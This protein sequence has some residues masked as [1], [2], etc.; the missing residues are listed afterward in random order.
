MQGFVEQTIGRVYC[1]PTFRGL[2][3]LY[4]CEGHACATGFTMEALGEDGGTPRVRHVSERAIGSTYHEVLWVRCPGQVAILR[5]ELEAMDGSAPSASAVSR[6]QALAAVVELSTVM[7]G[8]RAAGRGGGATPP[9]PPPPPVPMGRL[10][11]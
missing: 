6:R 4:Y 3:P 9:P 8:L 10:W 2:G 7:Q 1:G 11:A 5:A